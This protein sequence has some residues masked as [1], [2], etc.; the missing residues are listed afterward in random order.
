[1]SASTVTTQGLGFILNVVV[2]VETAP[3]ADLLRML[4]TL[5][6]KSVRRTRH[7]KH[8]KADQMGL[9]LSTTEGWDMNQLAFAA[10]WLSHSTADVLSCGLLSGTPHLDFGSAMELNMA[11]G[12]RE[13]AYVIER[14]PAL[15]ASVREIAEGIK[16][17]AL[18][19]ALQ[20]LGI[21]EI[22]STDSQTSMQ[23]LLDLAVR[24]AMADRGRQ[25]RYAMED[26]DLGT[27]LRTFC[28]LVVSP[29]EED[30]LRSAQELAFLWLTPAM[31]DYE[32]VLADSGV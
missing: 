19:L 31:M 5:A 18:E 26:A 20:T 3:S 29:G 32:A 24:L 13:A 30:S 9:D 25:L 22:F 14:L 4:K 27:L 11:L 21:G 12:N 2:G 8:R 23:A 1:M 15:H 7:R 28:N 16:V 10:E 6:A 17:E